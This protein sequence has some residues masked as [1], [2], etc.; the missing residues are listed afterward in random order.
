MLTHTSSTG[1]G[2]NLTSAAE[3]AGERNGRNSGVYGLNNPMIQA[4]LTVS[5][6]DDEYE[7][8][9]DQ[10]TDQIMGVQNPDSVQ[11]ESRGP[12]PV[13]V[14]ER[15]PMEEE[16]EELQAKPLIQRQPVEEEEEELRTQPILQRQPLEEEEEGE[17]LS[18][19]R[20][21]QRRP[22]LTSNEETYIRSI[23][24]AGQPLPNSAQSFFESRFGYDFS[25]VRVHDDHKAA[26][27]A[28]AINARAFTL[29]Q[30]VVFGTGGYSPQ[31][32]TGRK[33]LAHELAHVVQQGG[34]DSR[35]QQYPVS[36]HSK[37]SVKPVS[38]VRGI[39]K[40]DNK[41]QLLSIGPGP[42]ADLDWRAVPRGHRPRVRSAMKIINDVSRNR[43]LI[44]YF[45]DHAPGGTLNTLPN[46]VNRAVIW[47]LRNAGELGLSTEGGNDMAYDTYIYR[48]GKWQIAAT[49]IH[50]MGHLASLPTE[51]ECEGA[52]EAARTYAPFI[53]SIS[54]VSARVGEE[55]TITG[56]SFGP[57]Q[58]NVDHV[59]FNGVDAGAANTWHWRHNTQGVI[60][61][62]VPVGAT[63]G[64]VVVI[65]NRVRSNAV[66]FN[67][68]P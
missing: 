31:T 10:V 65:N 56:L 51:A 49:L 6:P 32:F 21:D 43:R 3:R 29:G 26:E 63:S 23:K 67:V 52:P 22:H 16:E 44:N 66:R 30:D 17:I 68:I 19:K 13:Q 59:Q 24:G 50:E 20:S 34:S 14:L 27:S 55:V 35:T 57:S 15:Q 61:I 41:V 58:S 36:T 37:K 28:R 54:P 60:R 53:E 25:R 38:S 62:N 42:T 8:E 39:S 47:E 2:P 4:K 33:L 9:A 11:R 64:N 48:I 5:R 7:R 45:R 46:V 1:K 40:L 18:A 12:V